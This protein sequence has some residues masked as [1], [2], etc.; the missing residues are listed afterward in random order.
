MSAVDEWVVA[1]GGIV[2]R[3][4][5][6]VQGSMASR[7]PGRVPT[8]EREV[9][10]GADIAVGEC[11]LGVPRAC[12]LTKAQ[13]EK[14]QAGQALRAAGE[15]LS[16]D[17]SY[18]TLL[19]CEA[20]GKHA[21]AATNDDDGSDDIYAC[22]VA[23]LP[24]LDECG[25]LPLFWGDDDLAELEG[26]SLLSF[27]D[28]RKM[29]I[30]ADYGLLAHC[31]AE[32]R[33]TTSEETFW[34]LYA[35]VTSRTFSFHTDAH[36]EVALMVPM[37]DM[38]ND[39]KAPDLDWEW[40]EARDLFTLTTLRPVAKDE[41]LTI[42]YGRS[43]N[44]A[45]LFNYGFC[46]DADLGEELELPSELS[47]HQCRLALSLAT[48]SAAPARLA[49]DSTDA[50][51]AVGSWY[52]TFVN[53][54]VDAPALSRAK[55]SSAVSDA[56][57]LAL[58][59]KVAAFKAASWAAVLNLSPEEGGGSALL[60]SSVACQLSVGSAN[61][62][63]SA[64]SL[65]RV[66]VIPEVGVRKAP[67]CAGASDGE[68][69]GEG[70]LEYT[71]LLRRIDEALALADGAP[72]RVPHTAA[73][74]NDDEVDEEEVRRAQE[75]VQGASACFAADRVARRPISWGNER[76]A[77]RAFRTTLLNALAAFPT[78]L[79]E[80]N[81]MLAHE[82]PAAPLSNNKRNAVVCRAGE[83]KVFGH[84]VRVADLA[85][86]YMDGPG[87]DFGEYCVLLEETLSARD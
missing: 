2:D 80:D 62:A 16:G 47:S 34:W 14:T 87:R 58:N 18:L 52:D 13:A 46:D 67:T 75:D 22:V 26:S 84:Y 73:A 25:H 39:D 70:E 20:L 74:D 44:F 63:T 61:A 28:I 71:E 49:P 76:R 11:V 31:S 37:A 7:S 56:A 43:A 85:L 64:L 27:L 33:E 69:E 24:P 36:Y 6:T 83:K 29:S 60:S 35:A 21:N 57:P 17:G 55:F 65:V 72:P 41:P 19:L 1:H 10:A 45:R 30:H 4:F 12:I 59:E 32:F 51:A 3:R 42:S 40:D 9:V 50:D 5:K 79:S 66:A 15:T 86:K 81:A 8:T 77:M 38:L 82:D 23:N 53:S 48:L 54:K 78:T 68:G